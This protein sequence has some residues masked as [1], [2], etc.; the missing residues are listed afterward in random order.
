MENR[1]SRQ[2]LFQPI[3][4]DGQ[5]KLLSKHILII[6]LGTLG[7]QSAEMFARAGIGKITIVD[8]DYIEWSNLQRQQLYTEEDAKKRL[9]KAIA[10]KRRLQEINS[11]I[12]IKAHIVDVT[13]EEIEWL[14]KDVDLMIDATDNFD[15]RMIMNDIA[16]K[17]EVTWIYGSCV[18]SYGMSFTVIPK[19][20]PC[21]HCLMVTV[22][23]DGPTCDTAGIIMPTSSRVVA[24]QMGE[25]LKILT[26]N[27]EA[28]SG[29]LLS[30]D[31]WS[32]QLVEMN[33][34]SLKKDDCPSCGE[35]RTYPFLEFDRQLKTAV[36]CGRDS[37]Q[38]RPSI[39]GRLDLYILAEQLRNT[40]GEV[41]KN[42]FLLSFVPN[43]DTVRI[44]IFEDGR[45][46]I[47]GTKDV[48]YARTMYYRYLG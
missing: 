6:G 46:I 11:E 15:I 47:H 44:V 32:N 29:K 34:S 5:N 28:L 8:R 3:G 9:P 38:I 48:E 36:L 43:D 21:L 37:V 12:E 33:V 26:D 39:D 14:I 27:E 17:H 7:A 35:R 45:A 42:P 41:E 18:G 10:A 30:F 31:V 22:P 16:Q 24:H 4:M 13:P 23:V 1:Y 20:T 2:I 25:A 19:K 40:G